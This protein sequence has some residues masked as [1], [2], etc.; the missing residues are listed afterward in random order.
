MRTRFLVL[1]IVTALFLMAA[2]GGGNTTVK[3]STPTPSPAASTVQVS[4]GDDPGD[5]VAS[6]SVT[7]NAISL[8]SAGATPVSVLP[9]PVTVE[10]TSLAGTTTPL[11]T[12]TVPAGTYTQASI[13]VG[14]MTVTCVDPN[15][16]ATVQKVFT[17]TQPFNVALNPAFVSDGTA[18]AINL[19]FDVARSVSI[20][21]QGNINI[22]PVFLAKH[23]PMV[24]PPA[25]TPPDPFKGGVDHI[26]GAVDSV[27]GTSFTIKAVVGLRT[28]TFTTNSSTVWKNLSG[29]AQLKAGMLV[30]VNAQAQADKTLLA[31][32]V[33]GVNMFNNATGAIGIVAKTTGT[34]VTQFQL[35]AH[36]L[37]GSNQAPTQ[38]GSTALF[39]TAGILVDVNSNTVFRYNQDNIDLTGV[40]VKFDAASLSPAQQ[41]EVDTTFSPLFNVGS[42]MMGALP[43][44]GKF[45]ASQV[46]LEQQP[47]VGTIS[48]LTSSGFTLT[49]S[50]DSVL[51]VLAKTTTITV[52]KQGATA[53]QDNLTLSN[54]QK[55]V[56]RGLLFNDGGYKLVAGRIGQ[57]GQ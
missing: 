4:I 27:S 36:G 8:S 5:R 20:D 52:Y 33:M 43:V 54:G 16:G 15:T 40:T 57:L 41:V 18:R 24:G 2:C 13:T 44:M 39:A 14:S 48:N 51:A 34:P 21:A 28:L 53:L 1:F 56:V 6:L 38:A 32:G 26:F 42:T 35:L 7:I 19:D 50:S 29:I 3:T 46:E 23:G 47:V 10:V 45:T 31:L 17:P 30:M 55:V 49:V 12:V 22:N 11:S 9:A 37:I 25:G